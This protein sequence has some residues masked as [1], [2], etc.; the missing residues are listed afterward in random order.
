MKKIAVFLLFFLKAWG[1][2]DVHEAHW[3]DSLVPDVRLFIQPVVWDEKAGFSALFET[4]RQIVR[5]NGTV[6]V[7]FDN[8]WI[9]KISGEYL[10]QKLGFQFYSGRKHTWVEQ[11]AIGFMTQ[12][13]TMEGGF[14]YSHAEGRRLRKKVVP[15]QNFICQRGIEGSDAF[16]V[17]WRKKFSFWESG[18]ISAGFLYDFVRFSRGKLIQGPG[19][20]IEL[21]QS[22]ATWS[23]LHLGISLERPY[24][25]YDAAISTRLI[26]L[27]CPIEIGIYGQRVHGFGSIP[28]S[29]RLGIE[30]GLDFGGDS[31]CFRDWLRRPGVYMPQVLARHNNRKKEWGE[32]P[33]VRALIG[34][35]SLEKENFNFDLNPYFSGTGPLIF[36]ASDLPPGLTLNP[37]T[38]KI[39]GAVDAS[40][41]G[42]YLV[43]V[44]AT[45]YFGSAFQEVNFQF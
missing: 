24:V 30:I 8:G 21:T 10:F 12:F 33:S 13:E 3:N 40:V 20:N 23:T 7:V 29:S 42:T 22:L 4:G 35:L 2:F 5:A 32:T 34:S 28:G 14:S 19:L 15:L 9:G 16:N 31:S 17:R 11:G 44:K 1:E 38:G 25:A 43:K 36:Q 45:N 39:S 6:G 41:K 37:G 27:K 18:V 26:V